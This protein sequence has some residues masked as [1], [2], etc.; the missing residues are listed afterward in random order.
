MNLKYKNKNTKISRY[1]VYNQSV[2]TLVFFAVFQMVL[3]SKRRKWDP[4]MMVR[5]VHTVR[6]GEMGY[7]RAAKYFNVPKRTLEGYV[8]NR[9]NEPEKLV[10]MSLGKKPVLTNEIEDSLVTY[11]VE[12]DKKCYGLSQKDVTQMAFQLACKN[13]LKHPFSTEKKCAGKKWLKGFLERHQELSLK[14]PQATS[15][16]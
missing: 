8:R 14:K 2:S 10:E 1:Q 7:M 16:A 15:F 13:G 9:A 4:T 3:P 12:M 11:C 5:A 6:S